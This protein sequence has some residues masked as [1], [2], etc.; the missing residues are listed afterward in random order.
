MS[1]GVP[2]WLLCART[3]TL[4][5]AVSPF[6]RRSSVLTLP[7]AP[8]R[9]LLRALAAAALLSA[10]AAPSAH[11]IDP[12]AATVDRT[13]DPTGPPPAAMERAQDRLRRGLGSR[14]LVQPDPTA[15][16]PRIV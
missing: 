9:A 7:A 4:S 5:A 16:T 2:G 11:A 3:T 15:G 6:S 14:A 1:A 12:V 10:V 13:T 8:P